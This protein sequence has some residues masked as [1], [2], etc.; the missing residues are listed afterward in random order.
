ML[1]Q[2]NINMVVVYMF[3]GI[4]CGAIYS[5]LGFSKKVVKNNL[6]IGNIIDIIAVLICGFV[7]YFFV[8]KYNLGEVNLFMVLFFV[9]GLIILQIF[10][11]NSFARLLR[12]VY[13][14][15]KVN[16]NLIKK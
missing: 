4:I 16:K 5:V 10:I 12:V 11:K 1:A 2:I 8:L 14:K 13:N 9:V 15:I 3:C 7:F 6:F